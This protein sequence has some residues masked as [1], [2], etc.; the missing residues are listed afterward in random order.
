MSE[1]KC[2]WGFLSTAGIAKKN[3]DSIRNSGSG[4]VTAVASRD[5]GRAQQF[6]NECQRSRPV[7]VMPM[8]VGGYDELLARAD[9]DAVYLPLPTGM[10]K[11]WVIKAANAGKH[12]MCE[13]PCAISAS[14]L[15]EMVEACQKNNVQFMDG[16]MFM[17]SQ[18]LPA[19]RR[20]IDDGK[21]I[22]QLKRIQTHFSFCAPDDFLK[23][24]IRLNSSLEPQGCLGDLGWYTIRMSL[25]VVN[26]RMP[27]RVI[28]RMLSETTRADS[29]DAVP[30][31]FSGELLFDEGV[32]AGF[33]NSFLTEHQQLVHISG[34]KGNIQLHDFVLP[35]FGNESTFEVNNAVFAIN[36]CEFVMERHSVR[37]AVA[38]YSNNAVDSQETNLFRKFSEIVL[39]GKVDPFWP[40]VSLKTQRILDACLESARNGSVPVDM[41]E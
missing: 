27:K 32:T 40:E 5:A 24:N 20:V 39:S 12:V 35:Y 19:L 13:K 1:I 4:V 16:V 18:R 15:Q 26:Y 37:H 2:R 14:D 28:G 7:D 31:E 29:P 25:F 8:A 23:S 33:Y 10:R 36:G 22:G 41:T 9:V 3:W 21:S 17:H 11:E 38:E 34:S 30:M 6:I